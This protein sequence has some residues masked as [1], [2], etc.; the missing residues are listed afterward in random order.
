MTGLPTNLFATDGR[1]HNAE[2][3]TFGHEC[4][5]TATWLASGHFDGSNFVSGFCDRCKEHGYEAASFSVWERIADPIGNRL[6]AMTIEIEMLRQEMAGIP[7]TDRP[8]LEGA[9]SRIRRAVADM[10]ALRREQNR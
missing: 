4:G 9:R 7:K 10:E 3:G 6:A 1:C 8:R 5:K 2:P